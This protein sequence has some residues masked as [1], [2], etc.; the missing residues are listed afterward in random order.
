MRIL[1]PHE[2]LC[3][4]LEIPAENWD[5]L[6]ALRDAISKKGDHY[7]N[8]KLRYEGLTIEAFDRESPLADTSQFGIDTQYGPI[9]SV[10]SYFDSY[11]S[12]RLSSLPYKVGFNTG[13][14]QYLAI[15]GFRTHDDRTEFL[16]KEQ[17]FWISEQFF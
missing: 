14:R 9:I 13:R 17:P 6:M 10:Y 12:Y 11:K 8:E 1:T 7:D 16:Q 3:V 4:R 2:E 15:I 5:R